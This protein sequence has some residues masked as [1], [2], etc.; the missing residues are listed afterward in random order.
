MDWKTGE[1]QRQLTSY[2]DTAQGQ[3]NQGESKKMVEKLWI[4]MSSEN[5]SNLLQVY[6]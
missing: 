2:G 4:I 1:N 3:K 6:R 5:I